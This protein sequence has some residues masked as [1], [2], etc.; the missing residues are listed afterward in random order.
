MV[1]P[2]AK[3]PLRAQ[4]QPEYGRIRG[5]PAGT[6]V[7]TSEED[8]EDFGIWNVTNFSQLKSFLGI[9]MATSVCN[10]PHVFVWL[11]DSPLPDTEAWTL[12]CYSFAPQLLLCEL[13]S[14]LVPKWIEGL[15][16]SGKNW[17]QGLFPSLSYKCLGQDPG[18][19]VSGWQSQWGMK[20]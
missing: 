4:K 1:F 11:L 8:G 18:W 20:Y 13:S 7:C 16:L 3:L 12:P 15:L 5:L 2:E 19:D 17:S 9:T 10:E 6:Q 14:W